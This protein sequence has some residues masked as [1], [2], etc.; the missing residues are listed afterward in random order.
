LPGNVN[1]TFRAYFDYRDRFCG[2]ILV[3]AGIAGRYCS[4]LVDHVHAIR[5]SGKNGVAEIAA[6]VIQESVVAQID[7]KL[8]S[9]TIHFTRSRHGDG[10][11][12][13][14]FFI[15]GRVSLRDMSEVMPPPW[16]MK[17]GMTL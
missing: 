4:Y 3:N 8:R 9:R 2:D 12:Q 14:S 6:A 5:N 17:F 13:A 16:I 10:T 11:A 7:E 15:G 1:L